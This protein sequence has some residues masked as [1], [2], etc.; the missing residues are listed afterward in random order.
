MSSEDLAKLKDLAEL[1]PQPG[2]TTPFWREVPAVSSIREAARPA[3]HCCCDP[4]RS[5]FLTQSPPPW[6]FV[7]LFLFVVF[8]FN[9]SIIALQCCVSFCC[10]TCGSA[11]DIHVG[12]SSLSLPSTPPS[13]PLGHHRASG[14]VPCAFSSVPP[15]IC[16]TRVVYV[17]HCCVCVRA[18]SLQSCP[19]LR[20]PIDCSLPGSSVHELLQAR[21]LLCPPPGHLP[22]LGV[23]PSCLMCPALKGGF[24]ATSSTLSICPTLSFP[25]VSTG[26]FSTSLPP[27][28]SCKWAHQHRFSRFPVSA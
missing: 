16:F 22:D 26:L 12:P 19:T 10:A 21:E 28:L 23:E 9:C 20:D 4:P 27:L 1:F 15:A 11:I 8:F 25:A 17:W 14:W 18:K 5:L 24:F 3:P 6:L 7:I 2:M 13:Q